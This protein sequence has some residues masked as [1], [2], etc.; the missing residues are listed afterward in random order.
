MRLYNT[1]TRE[2]DV[3]RPLADPVTMYVCGV[4]PYDTT[5]LGH[6]RTYTIFDVLQRYLRHLGLSVRYV[7]NVTDVDDPLIERANSLGITMEELAAKYVDIFLADLA[8]MN[9]L[10]PDVYPKAT[11]EIPGMIDTIEN[12]IA[13]GMAYARNGSVYFR[14]TR[15][16]S[17]GAMSRLT[18]EEMQ[19]ADRETGEDPGDPNKE[20]PLDFRLWQAARPN[21]PTWESPWGPG[22]PGWHIEC[23][24]MANRYLGPRIDIHG[25]GADLVFP[26]HCSEIA[27]SESANGV[28]PFCQHWVH[29]ALVWMDGEK[30][31]K[32]RGNMAFARDLLP[33][34]GGDALRYY[35]LTIHYR[36]R[37]EYVE[38][39]LRAAA[40]KWR[41]IGR[42][43]QGPRGG[44]PSGEAKAIE[45]RFTQAMEDDLDTPAALRA[46]HELADLVN[47]ANGAG[48][49]A[50]LQSLL[51]VLGFRLD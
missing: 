20:D 22:R 27:Q 16:P 37:L 38:D 14:A 6:A 28:G 15:F 34:Y 40:E 7:Q 26:H 36:Q 46:L 45:R 39:E 50:L 3:F 4:T 35:L 31:S 33:V 19:A 17:Y 2:K 9:I 43:L 24:T 29:I 25:G 5:H 1:M 11:E 51:Q 23:S 32:S 21:E 18:R 13:E 10:M 41:A 47:R 30:M 42:S 44:A 49:R 8:D 48:D 12:L